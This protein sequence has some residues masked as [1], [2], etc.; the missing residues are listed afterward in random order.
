M[1][2]WVCRCFRAAATHPRGNAT[3]RRDG[4]VVEGARLES[5][6]GGNVIAGSNPVL[7]TKLRTGPRGPIFNLGEQDLN[8]RF[9]YVV[10][11]AG[12][13]VATEAKTCLHFFANE[14]TRR[15]RYIVLSTKI[16]SSNKNS[17]M[18]LGIP[19]YMP[20]PEFPT[21]YTPRACQLCDS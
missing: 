13:G 17:G 12:F 6:Y 1:L 15:S 5:V 10:K 14:R 18:Y 21:T 8:L 7:S 3:P 20:A 9:F 4:R 2:N 19:R 11:V 16:T